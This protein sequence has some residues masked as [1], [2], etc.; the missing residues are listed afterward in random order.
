MLKHYMNSVERGEASIVEELGSG[1]IYQPSL[2]LR[3][4]YTKNKVGT[5]KERFE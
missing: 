3:P 5:Q 2:E 1:R 4:S